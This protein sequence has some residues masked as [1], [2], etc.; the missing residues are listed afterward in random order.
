MIM[1]NSRGLW[2]CKSFKPGWYYLRTTF[3]IVDEYNNIKQRY[4]EQSFI[5]AKDLLH[6]LEAH[7]FI[8]HIL[9]SVQ[10][11]PALT[12]PR[13]LSK[14]RFWPKG[15]PS[16]YWDIEAPSLEDVRHFVKLPGIYEDDEALDL[17]VQKI[18]EPKQLW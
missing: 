11:Y 3:D 6:Y 10:L 7:V 16:C 1:P 14:F 5:K 15:Q 2:G 13:K 4:T 8:D 17:T 9:I 12:K 18:P